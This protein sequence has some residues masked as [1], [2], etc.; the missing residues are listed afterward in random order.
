MLGRKMRITR[1]QQ[2]I[3]NIKATW[4]GIRALMNRD[5]MTPEGLASLTRHPI[6]RVE[7]GLRG[8]LEPLPSYFLHECVSVFR[9]TSARAKFIEDTDDIYSDEECMELLAQQA[10]PPRQG[11]FWDR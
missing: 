6:D 10:T 9:L 7:R 8:E 1:T 4:R 11:N 3:N 5:G 2:E